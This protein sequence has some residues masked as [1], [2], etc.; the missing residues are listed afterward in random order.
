MHAPSQAHERDRPGRRS[1]RLADCIQRRC[2]RREAESGGRDARAPNFVVS[3][4]TIR[5]VPPNHHAAIS[6]ISDE[7]L[8]AWQGLPMVDGLLVWL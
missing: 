7:I 1:R 8:A 6:R 5:I 2:F 3:D 4:S